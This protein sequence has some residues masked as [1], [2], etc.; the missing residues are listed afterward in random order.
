MRPFLTVVLFFLLQIFTLAAEA[1]L[2]LQEDGTFQQRGLSVLV[3]HDTYPIG[4]QG[5]IELIH[6]DQRIAANGNVW[7]EPTPGQWDAVAENGER[8]PD[9]GKNRVKIA[10]EYPE[11]QLKYTI[12]IQAKGTEIHI[13]LDL[14]E[15]V[16]EAWLGKAGFH[17][18]LYPGLLFGKSWLMDEKP[19]I[20]PRQANGPVVRDGDAI[21][22]M[23]MAEGQLLAVAP[24]DPERRLIIESLNGPLQ[25][26]DGRI[27]DDNG[28]FVLRSV[29]PAGK[30][31][32]AVSWIIRP[33][34]IDGWMR[35]P[36]ILHSQA[37]YHPNQ[38]KHILFEL[39][40]YDPG[41]TLAVLTRVLSDGSE[42]VVRS[43]QPAVWGTYL[44]YRYRVLDITDVTQPGIY[45]IQYGAVTSSPFQIHPDVYKTD[46]WQPTLE[47]FFP[48]QMCHMR[49][50][51]RFRV[52]HDACHLDDALQ[53]PVGH[54]HIDGYRQGAGTETPF[55]PL[56]PVPGLNRGGWH[57]AGDYDLAAG[58]QINT[59]MALALVREQFFVNS[60]QTRIDHQQRLAILHEPDGVP[61]I[62]Q[63]IKHGVLNILPGFQIAGHCFPGI[64]APTITQYVHL[65]ESDA[66][67][68]NQVFQAGAPDMQPSHLPG[69]MDDRWVFTNRST[70]LNYAAVRALAA[71]SRVL[72]TM[73]DSLATVCLETALRTW[74]DEQMR[75]PAEH[76]SAY[77]PGNHEA[78]EIMAAVEL[79]L[80]TQDQAFL[81]RLE[82]QTEV[83]A[84]QIRH[85]GWTLC[86]ILPFIEDENLKTRLS[87][88]I[89]NVEP[90]DLS[91]NPFG[92]TG[93]FHVWGI[94]WQIQQRAVQH[95]FLHQ[96]FP[97]RF[98]EDFIFNAVHY[99]LGC[100]PGSGTSLVSGVGSRSLTTAYGVNRADWSYIPG[101]NVS[102][103]ALIR[104]DFP[105]LKEPWPFL[106]Q[107]TEYVMGGAAS[108]IFCV[109]AADRLLS[110]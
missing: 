54:R 91:G 43:E 12:Q 40:P 53:A 52:W 95:Y 82:E 37:G 13:Q 90:P 83:I 81:M 87:E 70:A 23:P 48:V 22:P 31:K 5:G 105:E 92:V 108:Y 51:D 100:H 57:D 59:I 75:E 24:E 101:G 74:A 16:P 33:H 104:P 73:D 11:A 86:R 42:T 47:T 72:R 103:V 84:G 56:E 102:G 50:R 9:A 60:D 93:R 61:D 7:L 46:V 49:V 67:T 44:R 36:V 3:F 94:A 18:E 63:Q 69:T 30:K 19:G 89:L 28:W 64:I 76:R 80:T 62:L 66:M 45:R 35:S 38:P 32:S 41:G 34:V 71:A 58:S 78:E 88:L 21:V 1:G 97:D 10:C 25:L 17:L 79:F 65:G 26:L 55:A 29:I 98:Q 107:Q 39:D 110:L 8:M 15:P 6:H 20:F 85:V 96:A 109:L 77:V 106:W 4:H 14:E 2:Q 27:P 99:A 68:D